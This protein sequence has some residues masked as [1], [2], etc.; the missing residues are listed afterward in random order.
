MSWLAGDA[1]KQMDGWAG[2]QVGRLAIIWNIGG[3]CPGDYILPKIRRLCPE[4]LSG[5]C[6]R[7]LCAGDFVLRSRHDDRTARDLNSVKIR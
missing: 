6:V 2:G 4:E 3:L 1:D 5:D 7:G